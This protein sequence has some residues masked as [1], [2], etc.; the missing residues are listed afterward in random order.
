VL[1]SPRLAPVGMFDTSVR[2]AP[3]AETAAALFDCLAPLHDLRLEDHEL[4]CRAAIGVGFI[5]AM[6]DYS[7]IEHEL[8][9]L[10]LRELAPLEAF[11]V[12]AVSCLTVDRVALDPDGWWSR[13]EADDH[14]RILW[15]AAILRLADAVLGETGTPIGGVHAA[16]TDDM[17]HIEID[18]VSARDTGSMQ[19]RTAALEVMSGRRLVLTSSERRRTTVSEQVA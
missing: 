3:L 13:L 6:G 17:L 8:F 19:C 15:L 1:T 11:V 14:G 10:A 12:E 2:T 18:G 7:T 5:R 16:W 9:G 4:L